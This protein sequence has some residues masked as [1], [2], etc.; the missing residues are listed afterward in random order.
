M[1]L[2]VGF[3]CF[4]RFVFSVVWVEIFDVALGVAC[5]L[6]GGR[7]VCICVVIFCILAT[8][9]CLWRR[10]LL[11]GVFTADCIGVAAYIREGTCVC[12]LK[13]NFQT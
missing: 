5:R 12:C 2:D 6:G 7:L 11:T 1:Y 3:E 9:V 13:S 4:S 8:I 10:T